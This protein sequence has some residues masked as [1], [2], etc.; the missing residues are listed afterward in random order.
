[1]PLYNYFYVTYVRL[2]TCKHS[3]E[4]CTTFIT[5]SEIRIRY[6]DKAVVQ[7]PGL[8]WY[9]IRTYLYVVLL[10][11]L[12]FWRYRRARQPIF[13]MKNLT[14]FH[15]YRLFKISLLPC[16]YQYSIECSPPPFPSE[17]I[18]PGVYLPYLYLLRVNDQDIKCTK[19]KKIILGLE[20]YFSSYTPLSSTALALRRS[21][22]AVPYRQFRR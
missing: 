17:Q 8:D 1:M 13:R 16:V 14:G 3:C 2:Y 21:R 5:A 20:W 10:M 4:L 18:K 6:V 19:G 15:H 7:Y 9:E 22:K 12:T 11:Y